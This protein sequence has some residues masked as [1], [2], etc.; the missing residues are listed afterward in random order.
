MHA[1]TSS[2]GRSLPPVG[3][4]G[5]S[6]IHGELEGLCSWEETRYRSRK[7]TGRNPLTFLTFH[8]LISCQYFLMTQPKGKPAAQWVWE[9]LSRGK[10]PPG[11]QS[12]AE[13]GR[14]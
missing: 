14:R 5:V 2:S 7:R 4:I 1:E 9:E 13:N 10:R 12:R 8:S 11:V 3:G 6:G